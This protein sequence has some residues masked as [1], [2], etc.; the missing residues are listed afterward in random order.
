MAIITFWNGDTG[1]VGQSYSALAIATYMS[2]ENNNRIL[3]ISTNCNDQTTAQAFGFNKRNQGINIFTNGKKS[4][5]LESGIEGMSKLAQA[6]RL[7]PDA[8]PNYTKVVF[9]QRFELIPGPI[10]KSS[11][12]STYK[13]IYSTCED[14]INVAKRH[15]EYV[16]VDLNSGLSDETTRN[17][18]NKSDIIIINIEQ[19][20][21]DFENL[22]ELKKAFPA[23]KILVL[24]NKYDRESKY[25][26][27]NIKRFLNDKKEIYTI[28]YLNLYTEAVQEG[29]VADLFL[30]PR[31][32]N[33][34]DEDSKEG[35][36]I[37]EIKR[38]SDGIKFK[39]QE[40]Q[41]KA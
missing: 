9:N 38:A 39:L 6:S 16:F 23:D 17:I 41:M 19:K 31:I 37:K 7:T 20:I 40:L 30:N 29:N 10:D 24:I 25:T 28:P 1:K 13:R 5:D 27:K 3:L 34:K 18:L 35:F 8:I 2:I 32:R 36:F 15:Y 33:I 22:R 4:M 14:I 11:D 21:D 12:K 26:I